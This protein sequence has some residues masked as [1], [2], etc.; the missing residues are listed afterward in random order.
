[1]A[2]PLEEIEHLCR[3]VGHILGL[4]VEKAFGEGKVGFCLLLFDFGE[5]G[6]L[7]YIS[8][9]QRDSMIKAL[10]EFKRIL[11]TQKEGVILKQ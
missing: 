9:A 8:N 3:N 6:N 5:G 10:E 4:T 2:T 7:T 11:E 1:M